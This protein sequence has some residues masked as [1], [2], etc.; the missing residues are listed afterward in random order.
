MT[1]P[2]D[3]EIGAK[4]AILAKKIAD[5]ANEDGVPL[6]ARLDAFKHLTTYFVNTT[7]INSRPDADDEEGDSFGSF[8]KRIAAAANTVG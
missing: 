8:Q 3:D 4:L 6:D 5:E 1:K 2:Q 7:K